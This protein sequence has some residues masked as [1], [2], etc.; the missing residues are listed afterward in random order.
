MSGS[1][2]QDMIPPYTAPTA[3][4]GGR[5]VTWAAVCTFPPDIIRLMGDWRSNA[6]MKYIDMSL[7]DKYDAMLEF[8]MVMNTAQY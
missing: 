3:C 2:K 7:Q 5:G 1:V 6:Y 4:S 8:N